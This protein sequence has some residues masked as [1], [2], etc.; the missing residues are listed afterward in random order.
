MS[1]KTRLVVVLS[2]L[3]AVAFVLV[4]AVTVTQTR[5][6][7]IARVDETLVQ[8]SGKG[9]H[10]PSSNGPGDEIN[11]SSKR[12]IATIS[13][14]P[15][16]NVTHSEP[17]GFNDSPD[18]LPNLASLGESGL[19]SHVGV[20]FTVKAVGSSDLTY[21]VL[22]QSGPDGDLFAVA[23]PLSDVNST[24]HSLELVILLTSV[25]VLV[26]VVLIVWFVVREGL[27][28]IESMIDTAGL[29]ASGD[30]SQRV[31]YEASTN[32]VGK[33]GQALNEMLTQVESSFTA[34]EQSERKL[35]Q[36]AADASHEL[37]TPLTSIRGY[38]E[39][40]RSGAANDPE[41]LKRV[42]L[43]I[44][45]E[46]TR[47]GKLVDDLLLLARLD[48]GRSLRHDPV[49][50]AHII[51]NAVTDAEQSSRIGRSPRRPQRA[52]W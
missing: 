22:I 25:G 32:E 40:F 51:E 48:Q 37:R 2:L 44:E 3:V 46:S 43:R 45:S 5:S 15:H 13:F 16:G 31:E 34:K 49:N 21:R 19:Q 27:Q 50:L 1:I 33:L 35:R 10:F 7:M 52:S 30:L 11:S 14:D 47:M 8:A 26:G 38:A 39:L 20:P 6:N 18:P 24:I 12:S 28:P 41:T 29:I 17:S 23:E 42:M 4:G 9:G 36:F